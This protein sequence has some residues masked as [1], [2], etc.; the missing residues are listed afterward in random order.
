MQM[1]EQRRA[2][3]A[4]TCVREVARDVAKDKS[5]AIY[6]SYVSS[7]GAAIITMGLGQAMATER[8]AKG[9]AHQR[10]YK[11][12][13]GWLCCKAEPLAPFRNASDALEAICAAD[14]HAYLRAHAEALAVLEWL[15]KFARALI[16]LDESTE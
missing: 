8:Q 13:N 6:R 3:Y 4:L 9:G 14:Q 7:L 2:N 15:K 1:P 12:L 5:L 16:P 10:L 11:H